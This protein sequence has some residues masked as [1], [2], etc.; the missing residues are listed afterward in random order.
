[1]KQTICF[2]LVCGFVYAKA[3]DKNLGTADGALKTPVADGSLRY[4]LEML[5]VKFDA[6][7]RKL[8]ELQVEVT[9]HQKEVA[10]N[11]SVIQDR[12]LAILNLDQLREKLPTVTEPPI[13]ASCK[14]APVNASGVYMIRVNNTVSSPFKVYCEMEKFEGGWIVIQHRFNGSVDFN[15][16][17]ADYRNGFG[18][19][20]SEFWVGL[21]HIHLLTTSRT[22]ELIV[23]MEDFYGN[24]GYA[25]YNAF[26]IGS[27]SEQYSL[28][29][30]GSYSGTAGDSLSDHKGKKFSTKDRDND[31]ELDYDYAVSYEGAWWHHATYSNLNGPYRN[32]DDFNSNWWFTLRNDIRG[33]SFSRMMIR[34]L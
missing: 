1:M 28:K 3:T 32:I 7:D 17:W 26:Q 15:R 24:Y 9:E 6:M 16:N 20:E 34:K 31:E 2:L 27:E 4:L 18:E 30:V 33:M 25:R 13:Y 23:E 29:T 11:I 19:L 12:S 8:L 22:H 5:L 10:R 21:E 14:D